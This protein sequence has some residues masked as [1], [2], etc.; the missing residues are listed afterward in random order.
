M[1]L[2][3]YFFKITL[4]IC[5]I[6]PLPLILFFVAVDDQPR[7]VTRQD[8]FSE[9]PEVVPVDNDTNNNNSSGI[10]IVKLRKGQELKLKGIAKKV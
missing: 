10:I 8:L 6:L 9:D 1:H 5:I 3:N 7:D 4:L 2:T